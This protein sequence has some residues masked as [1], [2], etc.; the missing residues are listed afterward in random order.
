M[1]VDIIKKKSGALSGPCGYLLRNRIIS[2]ANCMDTITKGS[3]F[4]IFFL[5]ILARSLTLNTLQPYSVI[6]LTKIIEKHL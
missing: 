2:I 6:M 1:S 3:H 5:D 4:F